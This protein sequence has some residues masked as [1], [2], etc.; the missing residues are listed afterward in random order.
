MTAQW[1]ERLDVTVIR[2]NDLILW[3]VLDLSAVYLV[4]STVLSICLIIYAV[5]VLYRRYTSLYI[6]Y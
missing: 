5:F 4:D 3:M 6:L 2:S 1:L